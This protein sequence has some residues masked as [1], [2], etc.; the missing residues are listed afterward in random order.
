MENPVAANEDFNISVNRP[1]TVVELAKMV[2]EAV[3]RK[4]KFAIEHDV[5][6]EYDVKNRIPDTE[7]ARSM[8][9]FIAEISLEDSV[10]EVLEYVRNQKA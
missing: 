6:Y 4:E 9:G 2:W 5:P 3:G 10:K 8:L 7:K 1:T